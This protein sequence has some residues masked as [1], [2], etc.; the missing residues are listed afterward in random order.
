MG[1]IDSSDTGE[2]EKSSAAAG[3]QTLLRVLDLLDAVTR[4]PATLSELS[5]RLNLN[6][7]TVHRLA[8]ALVDRDYLRLIPGDG[9]MLGHKL[10]ELGFAARQQ[11]DLARIARPHLERLSA[12]TEDTVHLG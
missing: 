3:S 5:R 12:A 8:S 9:Y 10:L 4:S 1:M 2:R 7:S 6:R 11:L